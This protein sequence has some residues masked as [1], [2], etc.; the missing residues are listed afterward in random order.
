MI[1]QCFQ[2]CRQRY[3][4]GRVA[5]PRAI[6]RPATDLCGFS[7]VVGALLRRRRCS[8][9]TA[10]GACGWEMRRPGPA[11]RSLLETWFDNVH[12]MSALFWTG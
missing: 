5:K 4:F 11:W 2:P 3:A 6:F 10:G 1:L 7:R 8:Y 9:G 12:T